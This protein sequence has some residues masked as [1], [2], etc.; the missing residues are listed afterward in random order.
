MRWN[1][2]ISVPRVREEADISSLRGN[3]YSMIVGKGT[4]YT[5]RSFVRV[6]IGLFTRSVLKIA[7]SL[8]RDREDVSKINEEKGPCGFIGEASFSRVSIKKTAVK[9]ISQP[10]KL[11][12]H[13]GEETCS[14]R[15]SARV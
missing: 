14:L 8:G 11:Y 9:E 2:I 4:K 3:S 7:R 5:S 1:D 12:S 10:T 15:H 13:C 6:Q